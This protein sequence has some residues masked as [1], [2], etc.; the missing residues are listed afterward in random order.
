M[1]NCISILLTFTLLAFTARANDWPFFRGPTF[2]GISQE[3]GWKTTWPASGPPQIWS[4]E[5]GI[6]CASMVTAGSKVITMGNQEDRDIV[7]CLDVD[8]GETIWTHGYACEFDKRMFEGGTAS[9]PTIHDGRV[10][11]LSYDGQFF[12]LDLETGAVQWKKHLVEDFGGRLARWKYS[13]SP[14]VIGDK[15]IVETG[16][17]GN[18]TLALDRKTGEKIWGVGSDEAGYASP[19]PF[20]GADGEGVLMFKG[21]YMVAHDLESGRE[22][23]RIPWETNYDVNASSP[24]ALKDHVLISSGYKKGR[25]VLMELTNGEPREVWRNDELKT[26]MSSCVVKNGRVYGITEKKAR[27]LCLDLLT[28]NEVYESRDFSQYGTL[29]IA[30]NHILALTEQ[31]ELVVVEAHPTEFRELARAKILDKRC[32]VSPVLSHGRVFCKNNEGKLVCLDMR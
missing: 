19:I 5:V 3:S 4:K 26:K 29:M 22:L 17:D 7:W 23:W 13:C 8:S 28:G 20:R 14:L 21:K 6:G 18:S 11:T 32:W 31:G 30:G 15:V 10:Y 2:N 25:T 16:G 1:T 27:L 9:T 24:T 12:C